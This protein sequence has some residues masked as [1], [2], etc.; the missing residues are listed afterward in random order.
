MASGFPAFG[1][2]I[3]AIVVGLIVGPLSGSRLTIK[4]PAAGLIAL[5][6]A[7]VEAL[8]Q[9]DMSAGYRYTLAAIAAASLI[10]M[11][12]AV[13]KLGRFSDFS[14]LFSAQSLQYVALFA[15]IGSLE[16]LL[17]CKAI[18]GLDPYQRKS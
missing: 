8:G 5:A 11:F 14:Q 13:C 9:R 15:L 3:T 6:V 18:D 12:F 1:G 7:S 10:Q 16:S 17:T 2:V 4:G